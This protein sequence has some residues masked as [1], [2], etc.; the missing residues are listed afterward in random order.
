M[1]NDSST[2]SDHKE[3]SD[4]APE[5]QADRDPALA[6]QIAEIA[7]AV[8][9]LRATR[10]SEEVA[11]RAVQ[12]QFRPFEVVMVA[13]LAVS[14]LIHALTIA[15]LLSVRNT[16]RD[17]VA[18]LADSVQAA[19]SSQV[20][21]DL[22]IDQQLPINI[23]VPIKR[24]LDVPINTQ[25]R[26]KQDITLPVD[27]GFGTVNLPIPLDATIPIS[28]TVPIALDQTVN[29]STTVPL[30]LNVP[31]QIDLGSGQISGYL[32]RLYQALEKLRDRF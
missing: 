13:L 12:R 14:L 25:V 29:I 27:T 2:A 20:R 32:D 11:T 9:E 21:Y 18:R 6:E 30:K 17:E 5:Q 28:M 19:K 16:L 3:R 10:I 24:A 8:A 1:L 26:I 15:R 4:V 22:P 7:D 23:D 31:I